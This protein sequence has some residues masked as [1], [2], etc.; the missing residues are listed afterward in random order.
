MK[1]VR[2][3]ENFIAETIARTGSEQLLNKSTRSYVGLYD[4]ETSWYIPLRSNLGRKKTPNAI[5]ETPFKTDNPHFKRAGLDFEKSLFVPL[6]SVIE[7]Q[8]TLPK[9][10]DEFIK[11]NEDEIREKFANYIC[12]IKKMDKTSTSYLFSTAALF[13]EGI[14][15]IE[16]EFYTDRPLNSEII[17]KNDYECLD[18]DKCLDTD[19]YCDEDID[20]DFD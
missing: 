4:E 11:D 18:T 20:I 7:I 5:F 9:E 15:Q 8:N 16:N 10:Q 2:I 6:D 1:I 14:E 12:S 17:I 19:I 13:P 3:D